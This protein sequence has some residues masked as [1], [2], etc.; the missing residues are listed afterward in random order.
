MNRFIRGSDHHF[1]RWSG[2]YERSIMQWLLFDRIHSAV[3][4]A[5]PSDEQPQTVLD[6]GCGTGRLLRKVRERWPQAHLL[7]VDPTEG[8]INQ[9]RA[10]LPDADFYLGSAE[11]LPLPDNSVELV[12]STT[13]FHHWLDQAQ[14]VC[15]V[16][17]VLRPG[18]HFYLADTLPPPGWLAK[19]YHHGH[20]ASP[21]ELQAMFRQAE[22]K[23]VAQ[24]PVL[25]GRFYLWV[26]EKGLVRRNQ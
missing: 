13:S 23:T 2:T 14:G 1:E 17:R 15:E 12:L 18:G 9:A 21:T 5:I 22:L 10:G 19:V 3:L 20:M 4:A 16:T 6:I 25:G 11:K 24:Q 7:G 26:G 8:M